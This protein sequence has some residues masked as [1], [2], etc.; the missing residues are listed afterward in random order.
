M[1]A[2]RLI[3]LC[4][5]GLL[6]GVLPACEDDDTTPTV[7]TSEL[8]VFYQDA[9]ANMTAL[10]VG[11]TDLTIFNT[12]GG[13]VTLRQDATTS[14][15][16]DLVAAADNPTLLQKFNIPAGDYNGIEGQIDVIDFTVATGLTCLP[17]ADLEVLDIPRIQIQNAFIR[18]LDD[19]SVDILI[20][21]PIVNGTCAE[22]GA[23]GTLAFGT[24]TLSLL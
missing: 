24:I 9:P 13:Q 7:G 8:G 15:A 11:F 21:V 16:V 20:D 22:N 5:V 12:A 10:R 18:A 2:K 23:R 17:P 4:A 14:A 6:A 3:V 1:N 19:G